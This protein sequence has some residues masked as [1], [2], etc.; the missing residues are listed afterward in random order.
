MQKSLANMQKLKVSRKNW[1]HRGGFVIQGRNSECTN[2]KAS[3]DF[4]ITDSVKNVN[5]RN[6]VSRCNLQAYLKCFTL[7]LKSCSFTLDD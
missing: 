5:L 6:V 7:C 2:C 1:F 4:L 3:E